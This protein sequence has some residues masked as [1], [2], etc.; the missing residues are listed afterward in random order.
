[1]IDIIWGMIKRYISDP[2]CIILLVASA[3]IDLGN[4]EAVDL[5]WDADPKYERTMLVVNKADLRD[6]NFHEK[7]MANELGLVLGQFLVVNRS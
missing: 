4:S 2:K 5:A 7:F 1:M 3:N 6:K